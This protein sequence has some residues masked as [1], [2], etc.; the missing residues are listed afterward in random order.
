VWLSLVKKAA[1]CLSNIRPRF[2][3]GCPE[4]SQDLAEPEA[5]VL[6]GIFIF[7]GG[8]DRNTAKTLQAK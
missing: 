5:M 7:V 6:V 8:K 1:G 2:S 3:L 4:A